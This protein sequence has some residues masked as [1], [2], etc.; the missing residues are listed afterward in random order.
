MIVDWA[1]YKLVT[2]D[3]FS[4]EADVLVALARAQSKAE[5]ITERKFDA[6]ERTEPLS[7]DEGGNV[8]PAAYPIASVSLPTTATVADDAKSIK[9]GTTSWQDAVSALLPSAAS[10]AVRPRELV[11]YVGGYAS[12][13]EAPTGLT[14]AICELAHRYLNPADMSTVPAGATSISATGQSVSGGKLG[15]AASIPPALRQELHKYDHINKRTP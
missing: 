15:G 4:A 11:T 5:E 13:S 12:V 10:A 14:D 7:V 8:W 6:G 3:R 9:T 2:G 1:T